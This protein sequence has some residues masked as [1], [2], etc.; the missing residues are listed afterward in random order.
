MKRRTAGHQ[1]IPPFV[2]CSQCS[3]INL[4][5]FKI[6]VNQIMQEC[7]NVP[8]PKQQRLNQHR[9]L[10]GVIFSDHESV[11]SENRISRRFVVHGDF[12]RQDPTSFPS[13]KTEEP[14][15]SS[16][17]ALPCISQHEKKRPSWQLVSQGTDAFPSQNSTVLGS[18][19]K[20][21]KVATPCLRK[22][23]S[24]LPSFSSYIL[25][26]MG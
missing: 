18:W 5:L 8:N 23:T 4:K 6:T 10:C 24:V 14:A 2:L 13:A 20:A 19:P 22:K 25:R 17:S 1:A 11:L 9:D 26:S 21:Q 7:N 16:L 15:A 3:S 12:R